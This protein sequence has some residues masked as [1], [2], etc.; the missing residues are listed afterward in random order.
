MWRELIVKP[1]KRDQAV[2]YLKRL[3]NRLEALTLAKEEF[4]HELADAKW[5][6][7]RDRVENRAREVQDQV[8]Q[9]R[10]AIGDFFE[11][12]PPENAAKG[13]EIQ[14][15]L[16]QGL[17]KKWNSLEEIKKNLQLKTASRD[18]IFEDADE[19]A[20]KA[21]AL[22]SIVDALITDMTQND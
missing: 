2:R 20:R 15:Q 18:E 7:D 14:E 13:S 1:A 4:A 19:L 22:K 12:L 3:S 5:P 11:T 10:R 16:R 21:A 9:V 6:E 17:G 8:W